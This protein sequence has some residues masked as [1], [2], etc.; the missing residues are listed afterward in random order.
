MTKA[1]KRLLVPALIFLIVLTGCAGTSAETD[2]VEYAVVVRNQQGSPMP[3]IKV[4]VYEDSSGTEL[5][6]VATTDEE[7]KIAF[8]EKVSDSFVAVF[9]ELPAGYAAEENYVL[10]PGENVITLSDR[11]LTP[12][13]MENI[14]FGLGDRL[15]D[16]TVVDCEG[17]SHSLH[18][19]LEQNKAVLLN[20]WFLNCGPCK[21]EFPYLQEA[22]ESFG[23]QVAFLALNPLDGTDETIKA[24][25][26]E[27]GLTIPMAVCEQSFQNMLG[28]SAYPT[29][30]IL[31]RYGNICLMHTGMFTDSAALENALSYFTQEE[32][33]P[34]FFET[35][36]EIP[37][38]Q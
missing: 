31:D 25:R 2:P 5:V 32:Y 17:N 23:E 11:E 27:Q 13:E 12:E 6:S 14:R 18:Q 22:Y 21:M 30:V 19:M 37:A 35:I 16:F 1:V 20:F 24:Y 26:T 9:Q 3:E 33:E 28:L 10:R 7:G 38:V 4:F 15:P 29:T 34:M 36:D 8:V